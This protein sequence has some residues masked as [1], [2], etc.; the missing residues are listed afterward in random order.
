MK[1]LIL[2]MCLICTVVSCR[3]IMPDFESGIISAFPTEYKK[4]WEVVKV[5]Y[6]DV[7]DYHL[8]TEGLTIKFN[9]D[10][11]I[12]YFD[13]KILYKGTNIAYETNHFTVQLQNGG[14]LWI[15]TYIASGL[16]FF[17]LTFTKLEN[18][19]VELMTQ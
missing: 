11:S 1:K 8:N 10:N 19:N 9:N 12:E 16:T 18:S 14:Q 5:R 3:N 15:T 17:K 13:G 6:G 7:K 4:P 2:A